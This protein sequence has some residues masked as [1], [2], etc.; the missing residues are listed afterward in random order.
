M[1]ATYQASNINGGN[2]G[3][4]PYTI[5]PVGNN[6]ANAYEAKTVL[7]A[8]GASYGTFEHTNTSVVGASCNGTTTPFRLVG[9]S[10]G[11][12]LAAAASSSASITSPS[13]TNLQNDKYVIVWNAT[14]AGTTTPP[15]ATSTVKVHVL[16]YVNGQKATASSTS[17]FQFPMSAT[18]MASNLN[19]GATSSGAYVLGNNHGG[20]ADQYGAD[21]AAM[22]SGAYY[23]TSE[24]T[25]TSSGMVLPNGAACETDKYRLLGYTTGT[26]FADAASKS[27]TLTAPSFSNLVSDQYV[28]VWNLQCNGS[29]NPPPTTS[30]CAASSTPAGYQRVNGTPGNDNVTLAPNTFFVGLGG[31]DK[32]NAG[33]GNYVICTGPGNDTITLGN[34]QATIDAGGGNNKIKHGDGAVW[35][36]TG[37][38]NDTIV[39]GSGGA[40]IWTNAGND[41]ITTGSGADVIDAGGGNNTVKSGSNNDSISSGSG[42]DTING[43]AGTD[44]CVP[45]GGNNNVS[46]CEL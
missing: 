6:T 4:D 1:Q 18:W 45:G 11:D 25:S 27:P 13:F 28:I 39:T 12:T 20:A 9:Y 43:E 36:T 29:Q 16:K 24:T 22:N 30:G 5:G 42:N 41:H 32:I 17:S 44:T 31:N 3:T 33:D 35:I 21:T 15:T 37:S 38:G 19:G 34:G 2:P 10:W 26:S 14:C 23:T 46:N 8:N 40:H 7:L